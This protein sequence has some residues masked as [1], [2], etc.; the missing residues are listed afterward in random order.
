MCGYLYR[1]GKAAQ[2]FPGVLAVLLTTVS[3]WSETP[4]HRAA[5]KEQQPVPIVVDDSRTLA[6]ALAEAAADPHDNVIRFESTLFTSDP[7]L[8]IND[9][10]I[11][12]TRPDSHDRIDGTLDT[13]PLTLRFRRSTEAAFE[14]RGEGMLTVTNLHMEGGLSHSLVLREGADVRLAG[15]TLSGAA[16]AGLVLFDRA[17]VTMTDSRIVGHR[18]HGIEMHE[19]TRATLRNVCLAGNGQSAAA[20]FGQADLDARGG[21]WADNGDWNLVL[22]DKSQASLTDC[23][24]SGAG[25]AQVDLNG[26]TA[27]AL[28]GCVVE[29]GRR[30]GLLATGESRIDLKNAEVRRHGSH[31]IELQEKAR[32]RIER[33]RVADCGGYGALLFGKARIEAD[34]TVFADHDAHGVGLRDAAGGMLRRC[35]FTGNRYS[36]V[37]C[38][39]AGAGGAVEITQ[40]LFSGNSQR[41]IA[42]GPAQIDPPVPTPVRI[43]DD[44]VE[45]LAAPD[46][47]IELFADPVGEATSYQTTLKA[48]ARGRFTVSRGDIP[49]GHVLTATATLGANTSEFN[50]VAGPRDA[51]PILHALLAQ[52]GP[53]SDRE[54]DARFGTRLR[55]WPTG[56]RLVLHLHNPPDPEIEHYGRF[57]CQMVGDWTG[58][59]VT[60]EVCVDRWVT[61]PPGAV[62]IPVRWIPA[63]TTP[64]TGRGGLIFLRWTGEGTF[65][66][67]I[68]ILLADGKGQGDLCHP[69]LAHEIGHALGLHHARVGLLSRMQGSAAPSGT[70]WVND[71]TAVPTFYDVLALHLLYDRASHAGITL[72]EV[73]ARGLTAAV[74]DLRAGMQASPPP[75][76]ARIN[77]SA[78]RP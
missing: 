49:K 61:L 39:D 45:C 66:P 30:F 24:L 60:A 20:L 52:T 72:G 25:F 28:D 40:C 37:S 67:G 78:N 14:L 6:D 53:L 68:E 50:V 33:S 26:S 19:Q 22:A 27:V 74:P 11:L 44:R 34:D 63:D 48:D 42:R 23:V 55:R 9:T 1:P 21:L 8:E 38:Q 15:V 3:A 51:G 13:G 32:L 18:T 5:V 43:H 56:T 41:P 17:R 77:P 65:T 73:V 36:G 62:L 71:F 4:P 47:R 54:E 10:L 12:E 2:A 57:V 69:I 35:R 46:A 16:G 70:C 59:A 29:R 7:V 75:P 31:G 58:G 76:P 64:L